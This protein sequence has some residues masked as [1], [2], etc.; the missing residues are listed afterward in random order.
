MDDKVLGELKRRMLKLV[1]DVAAT[2]VGLN[3]TQRNN[4]S[5]ELNDA[6]GRMKALK[7]ATSVL[8]TFRYRTSWEFEEKLA[9]QLKRELSALDL[10]RRPTRAQWAAHLRIRENGY[11][12]VET[13]ETFDYAGQTYRT[14][15]RVSYDSVA[16][17]RP[18]I[19][20]VSPQSALNAVFV[21]GVTKVLQAHATIAFPVSDDNPHLYLT[22]DEI[23]AKGLE[24]ADKE[25]AK[26][27]L[28]RVRVQLLN[29]LIQQVTAFQGTLS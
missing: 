21:N 8:D 27:V 6:I 23:D 10:A 18:N 11:R 4:V 13:T 5:A 14:H 7:D 20:G 2:F 24:G 15:F 3:A 19:F 29:W 25:R 17:T 1:V 12:L 9:E 26:Q 28:T 22:G 16:G